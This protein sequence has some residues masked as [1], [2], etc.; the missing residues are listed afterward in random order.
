LRLLGLRAQLAAAGDVGLWI[1]VQDWVELNR[2]QW[3]Q[4]AEIP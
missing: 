1:C 3:E 4:F 2:K